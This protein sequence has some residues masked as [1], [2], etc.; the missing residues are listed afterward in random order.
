MVG[1]RWSSLSSGPG[2]GLRQT[3]GV[4]ITQCSC[5]PPR[6]VYPTLPCMRENMSWV[7]ESPF[8]RCRVQSR[9]VPCSPLAADFAFIPPPKAVGICLGP[10][11]GGQKSFLIY[12]KWFKDLVSYE[13]R[14]QGSGRI[15][16]LNATGESS[17]CSQFLLRA[18]VNKEHWSED[19]SLVW[20]ILKYHYS[21]LEEGFLLNRFYGGCL[22][23]SCSTKVK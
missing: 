19:S 23:F 13:L 9:G 4:L 20:I 15:S 7:G 18:S 10:G 3:L 2:F 11:K 14:V 12:H 5:T 21:S 17:L 22:F 6:N 8:Y 16:G 1:V